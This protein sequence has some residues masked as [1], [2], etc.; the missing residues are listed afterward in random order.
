MT[1]LIFTAVYAIF[2]IPMAVCYIF[3]TIGTGSTDENKF[4]KFDGPGYYFSN[5]V[6]SIAVPI[7]ATFN[8]IVYIIRMSAFRAYILSYVRK[9]MLVFRIPVYF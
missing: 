7:N 8:P 9:V 6:F 4:F 2:N 5:L 1:I 3:H